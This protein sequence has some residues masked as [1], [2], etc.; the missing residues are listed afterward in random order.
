[1]WFKFTIILC[2]ITYKV[3]N[4][5]GRNGGNLPGIIALTINKKLFKHFKVNGEVIAVTGTNGK[6]FTNNLIYTMFSSISSNVI[7]NKEGN[8]TDT[9]VAT[10]LIKNC[11]L[12]GEVNCDY[13]V[14]EVDEHYIP[15]IFKYIELD[16]FVLLNFFR[17]QLDRTA[18]VE[19]LVLKIFD[20][21]KTYNGNLV[22]NADDS[23]VARMSK[24]NPNNKNVYFCG[25][26]KYAG[27]KIMNDDKR[28]GKYCP[29]CSNKF[30]Y[31][32][33]QYS[34]IGKYKCSSCGF[35]NDKVDFLIKDVDLSNNTFSLNGKKFKS[36]YNSI[37]S[38]Y[39][40][41]SVLGVC[42]IYNIP[43]KK[44]SNVLENFLL[45]NGRFEKLVVDNQESI[46]N[47]AKNPT[48][49]N[50]TLKI[51]NEDEDL[52]EILFILNDNIADGKDVSWIWDIDFSV[53]NKVERVITSGTR[54]YDIAVRIKNSGY[55]YKK[56]ECYPKLDEAV[57]NLYKTEN[58]KY[59]IFNYTAVTDV[60]NAIF[61]YKDKVKNDD[62]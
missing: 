53:L 17:D 35:G 10:T 41:S 34:H 47:L 48:G 51:I 5:F 11:N 43:N 54:A 7:C 36:N 28:E 40:I 58:K 62:L 38:M 29:F 60:R 46:L 8:N 14:L 3:L 37:Y 2:K 19:L 27:S 9:G 33:Y 52:K 30:D 22:L 12:K 59:V 4:L 25:V 50:V 6:T 1:M 13:L 55:D 57:S 18:E 39:N 23:N 49:V 56:I 24:A 44:V 26:D 45:N 32:Y 16:T 15:I 42:N 20:F 21:L 31:L 61:K